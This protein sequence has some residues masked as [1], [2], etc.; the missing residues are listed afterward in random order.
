[1][2]TASVLGLAGARP[3][4]ARAP[5]VLWFT[6]E[7]SK[8]ARRIAEAYTAATGVPV[9]VETP[10]PLD[11]PAKFQQA[12]AA[13]KGPDMYIY[14]HDRIGEWVASGL[15]RSVEP[16][17]R[18]RRDIDPLAWRGFTLRGRIWGYPYAMEAV[19]LVYNKALVKSPP[20][21]FEEVFALDRELAAQ[22][23]KALLWD[24]SNNYFS[25]PLFAANGGYAFRE[26]PDGSYDAS[27]TGVNNAGARVGAELLARLVREG[28]MPAGSGYAEMEAAL[29]QGRVAM[30]INGP[31]SWVNL[32]RV[33]IDFGVARI[34]AVA[35]KAAVPFVGIKGVLLSRACRQPELAAEFIENHLLA[36]PGLRAID[37]AEPIGAPA[38]QVYLA[39]LLA[40]PVV[41]SKIA[42]IVASAR[43]GVPTPSI[44]E[45]GRFWAAMK[46]ALTNLTEG[47]QTPQQ[48]LDA[49]ARRI[50]PA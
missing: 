22:G 19:T 26:R 41:G 7:G 28:L 44:P 33:G 4:F 15:L 30:M 9:I 12:A 24:Y 42:G 38:S 29:G 32:R 49:A 37:R 23:K 47:R 46:S 27:D 14:A 50:T 35:G 31:W 36:L 34:P 8:A 48:A 2:G 39:E 20:K 6:V 1:M 3:A 10:D 16:G 45:M 11:G 13:G 5:L 17:R 25:W 40:D 43:D 21:T 18:M